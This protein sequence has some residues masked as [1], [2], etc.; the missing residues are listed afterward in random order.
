[1][2]INNAHFV[3]HVTLVAIA[4]TTVLVLYH[5]GQVTAIYMYLKILY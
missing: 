5:T 1:M 4:G 2:A 3:G